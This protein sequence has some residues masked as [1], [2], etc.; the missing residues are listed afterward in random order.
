MKTMTDKQSAW[1][2]ASSLGTSLWGFITLDFVIGL[3]GLAISIYLAYLQHKKIKAEQLLAEQRLRHEQ[4][5]HALA[6]KGKIERRADV[7]GQ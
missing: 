6:V 4:E 7:C 3:A 1:A 5:L 2:Q